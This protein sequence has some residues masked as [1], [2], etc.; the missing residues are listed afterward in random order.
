MSTQNKQVIFKCLQAAFALLMLLNSSIPVLAMVIPQKER[1]F[2]QVINNLSNS[3]QIGSDEFFTPTEPV[4]NF[5]ESQEAVQ[6]VTKSTYLSLSVEPQLIIGD[7]P[8]TLSWNLLDAPEK[9]FE[10][11]IYLP[12]G[13]SLDKDESFQEQEIE[14]ITPEI[15]AKNQ[16]T[17]AIILY[18]QDIKNAPYVVVIQ[19]IQLDEV[20]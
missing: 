19:I 12:N 7:H 1:S 2:D 10:V 4:P 8:I 13:I 3:I 17:G 18:V 5:R 16:P 6:R 20:L 11:Q 9:D 14:K 15:I